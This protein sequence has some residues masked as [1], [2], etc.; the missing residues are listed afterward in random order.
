MS[1][2]STDETA[3]GEA[4]I[5]L[6]APGYEGPRDDPGA[7]DGARAPQIRPRRRKVVLIVDDN[8]DAAESLADLLELHG[9]ATRVAGDGRSAIDAARELE[10]DVLVCDVGLPDMSGYDVIREI[11]AGATGARTLAIALTG[12]T[13]PEDRRRALAA[14]FDAHLP[15]P[16]PMDE[17]TALLATSQEERLRG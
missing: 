7:S 15:K 14:G 13:R 3:A 1:G 12:Y 6:T 9:H 5:G 8:R 16:L 10:P 2:E 11:R 4:T 17:L